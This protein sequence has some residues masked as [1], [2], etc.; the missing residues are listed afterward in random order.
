MGV[1]NKQNEEFRICEKILYD[2]KN[3]DNEIEWC[4]MSIEHIKESDDFI[5]LKAVQYD[6][7]PVSPTNSF[8]SSVENAVIKRDKV[9]SSYEKRIK[10]LEYTREKVAIVLRMLSTSELKLIELRYLSKEPLTWDQIGNAM[11]FCKDNCMIFRN[12]TIKKIIPYL[13]DIIFKNKQSE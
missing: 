12:K 1:K 7:D 13:E 9:I 8:G 2:Y 4:N 3:I 5:D 10:Q 6:K 11:G